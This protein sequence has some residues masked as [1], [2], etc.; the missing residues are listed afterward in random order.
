MRYLAKAVSAIALLA[1]SQTSVSV[2]SEKINVGVLNVASINAWISEAEGIWKEQGLDVKINR[3]SSGATVNEA[4]LAGGIDF[5]YIGFGPALFAA[6]RNLPFVYVANGAYTDQGSATNAIVVAKNSSIK[7][8]KDLDGK[9][10][11]V[12]TK[13]TIEHIIAADLSE[14]A[15]ISI[16][17]R[18][19]PLG[20]QEV[21]LSRGDVDAVSAHTPQT[22]Y[23]T[24]IRGHRAI[25]FVPNQKIPNFQI[26]TLATRRQY[27]EKNPDIV[28]KM[29]KAYIL[30]N[31]WISEHPDEAKKII[32][33]KYL[34][35]DDALANAMVTLKWPKNGGALLSSLNY[36]SKQMEKLKLI[37]EVPPLKNY[38]VDDYL[39]KA[40]L[41]LKP[42]P[43]PD[44]DK[45][46]AAKFPE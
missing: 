38:F 5:G 20:Q 46:K 42:V 26:I 16:N 2:A 36:F 37:G 17:L 22:E 24:K 41:D 40:L 1:I 30:T 35:Y 28:V 23:M 3:F 14:Q 27:A 8:M 33:T 9:T 19:I 44:F 31:R 25:E 15:G 18:E 11:A 10:V 4:L 6:S 21:A 45:A 34:N 12:Q 13:G 43:D 39:Q 29:T 7:S 32:S